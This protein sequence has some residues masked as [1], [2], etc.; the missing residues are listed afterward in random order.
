M[1]NEIKHPLSFYLD[2]FIEI[3]LLLFRIQFDRA[4]RH[5]FDLFLN[6]FSS[7]V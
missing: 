7:K 4:E 6:I 3:A 2:L 1:N 5:D